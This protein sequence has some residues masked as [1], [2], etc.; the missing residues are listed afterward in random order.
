MK[1]CL[2]TLSSL[3]LSWCQGTQEITPAYHIV[4]ISDL[5]IDFNKLLL[6][7]PMGHCNCTDTEQSVSEPDTTSSST[8][9]STSAT[10]TVP[11]GGSEAQLEMPEI[12]QGSIYSPQVWMDH[13]ARQQQR[14][15]DYLTM[16]KLDPGLQAK[17][18]SFQ[19]EMTELISANA[20]SAD[21][22]MLG[23]NSSNTT[24][25]SCKATC[26]VNSNISLSARVMSMVHAA[27]ERAS[28]ILRKNGNHT[29][30]LLW[31]G[32]HRRDQNEANLIRTLIQACP[33][34][35]K[36]LDE[37][38]VGI[39]TGLTKSLQSV[40]IVYAIG[41]YDTFEPFRL[42]AGPNANLDFLADLWKSAIPADQMEVFRQGGY[43]ALDI[44]HDSNSTNTTNIQVS[45][46]NGTNTSTGNSTDSGHG[47]GIRIR[48]ISLNTYY[49][50]KYNDLVCDCNDFGSPGRK[51]LLWLNNQLVD[52]AEKGMTTYIVGH[53]APSRQVYK[54]ACYAGYMKLLQDFA[55]TIRTEYPSVT[56]QFFD[57]MHRCSC[58]DRGQIRRAGTSLESRIAQLP[59]TESFIFR[60]DDHDGADIANVLLSPNMM[61]KK[62]PCRR[63]SIYPRPPCPCSSRRRFP[64]RRR[65][66]HACGMQ[67]YWNT[68]FP[69]S[70]WH[71]LN[72]SAAFGA[73]IKNGTVND[74]DRTAAANL[75]AA[76]NLTALNATGNN[77]TATSN[78]TAA[79][80]TDNNATSNLTSAT[81][82]GNNVSSAD[83]GKKSESNSTDTIPTSPL[84]SNSTTNSTVDSTNSTANSTNSTVNSSNSTGNMSLM[85]TPDAIVVRSDPSKKAP[86]AKAEIVVSELALPDMRKSEASIAPPSCEE[87]V[88]EDMISDTI[89][90]FFGNQEEKEALECKRLKSRERRGFRSEP[91]RWYNNMARS[92]ADIPVPEPLQP[93]LVLSQDPLPDLGHC[94]DDSLRS[95]TPEHQNLLSM[96]D[97]VIAACVPVPI[98][99][100]P[101][102][103]AS[104]RTKEVPIKHDSHSRHRPRPCHKKRRVKKRSCHS[105]AP[106]LNILDMD[107]DSDW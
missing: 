67:P 70:S 93:V 3:A 28:E 58:E 102:P 5:G 47:D 98:R 17:L 33:D 20:T 43:Y 78:L 39:L 94:L 87:N 22:S 84:L 101:S 96:M 25:H 100:S 85:E 76:T 90:S 71:T 86:S 88:L 89:Q 65:S 36:R 75:T 53:L 9:A 15:L 107:L 72:N 24:A 12:P 60:Y 106:S 49:F 35:M 64:I 30:A 59:M 95:N 27:T 91:L 32:G 48:I 18:E 51:Q 80:S 10:T 37:L 23:R 16:Y 2:L 34:M 74:T 6:S 38:I 8:H 97:D 42:P 44:V 105:S 69:I 99:K 55:P 81:E 61:R 92:L 29:V 4:H 45:S 50:A 83:T 103:T 1:L 52:A 63:P 40:P 46:A 31:T 104:C 21:I 14:K 56:G 62:R 41:P 7:E 82:A 68:S 79:N 66:N 26:E 19:E 54:S 11:G 77:I 73:A 57:R 13:Y